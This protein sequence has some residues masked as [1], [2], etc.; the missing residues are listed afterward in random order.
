MSV[1]DLTVFWDCMGGIFLFFGEG[2]FV[3]VGGG[4]FIIICFGGRGI[5]LFIFF[6]GGVFFS[7]GGAF[8]YSTVWYCTVGWHKLTSTSRKSKSLRKHFRH[9]PHW[10][11]KYWN[12]FSCHIASSITNSR[13]F[14]QL[15]IS[16]K[17]LKLPNIHFVVGKSKFWGHFYFFNF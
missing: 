2:L 14:M 8:F 16:K 17:Y 4:I 12:L 15:T 13:F 1:Q 6:G 3:V 11:R 7:G 10:F 9:I 5:F